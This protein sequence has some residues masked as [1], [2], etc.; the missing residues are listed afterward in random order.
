M[1]R[2]TFILLA[3]ATGA[4]SFVVY[5][6]GNWLPS[7]LARIH[8]MGSGEIGSWLSLGSGGAGALGVW[9]GGYL[10]DKYGQ[11]DRRWYLWIPAIAIL[12]SLPLSAL[13][14]TASHKYLVLCTIPIVKVLWS[15]YLGP[16]IAMAHRMVG[17]RMRAMS[18][19]VLF[20]VLNFIGLGLGPLI[21]GT[22]SDHFSPQYGTESLRW[23]MIAGLSMSLLGA[24][25]YY[26]ASR[27]L[28]SDIARAP[29]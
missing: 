26:G 22:I 28:E 3:L 15:F 18:S 21:I 29:L 2:K 9:L 14:L 13:M 4:H 16:S 10:T 20:L 17:I 11:Q 25:L 7:L 19:A 23:A 8:D 6:L 5:G 1:T 24:V 12:A 27:T